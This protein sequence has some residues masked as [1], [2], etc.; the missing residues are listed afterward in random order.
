MA[1]ALSYP[2]L[3]PLSATCGLAPQ[4]LLHT[5]TPEVPVIYCTCSIR[6][7]LPISNLLLTCFLVCYKC[8]ISV[9][10]YKPLCIVGL[11][12]FLTPLLAELPH[13]W[14]CAKKGHWG[15]KCRFLSLRWQDL[16][17]SAVSIFIP[18]FFN[19]SQPLSSHH[20]NPVPHCS[21]LQGLVLKFNT[22]AYF[23]ESID[24]TNNISLVCLKGLWT[25]L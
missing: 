1:S 17:L 14:W 24:L 19:F 6:M 25:L 7:W 11:L 9:H 22:M 15:K 8:R 23:L 12:L 5:S 21:T 18:N 13:F 2:P 10:L 20:D 3:L 4:D 16:L